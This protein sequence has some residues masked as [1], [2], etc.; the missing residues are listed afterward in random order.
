RSRAS[1]YCSPSG[2]PGAHTPGSPMVVYS[3]KSG[4]RPASGQKT[5]LRAAALRSVVLW[6]PF[7]Q[8]LLL[9][10]LVVVVLEGLLR[11]L[12]DVVDGLA[13]VVDPTLVRLVIAV[14]GVQFRLLLLLGDLFVELVGQGLAL[15]DLAVIDVERAID[16]LDLQRLDAGL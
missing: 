4:G 15:V 5:C 3:E 12:P 10:N 8:T 14:R 11:G 16:L 9:G 6:F 1:R 7:R 2:R 13:V